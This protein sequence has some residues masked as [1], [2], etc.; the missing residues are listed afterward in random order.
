M[1]TQECRRC[2]GGFE[3]TDDECSWCG[4]PA[5]VPRW[6]LGRFLAIFGLA[7]A[8]LCI[9]VA[10]LGL[11][12][13]NQRHQPAEPATRVAAAPK[14]AQ[15]AEAKPATPA[16]VTPAPATPEDEKPTEGI[17]TLHVRE[18]WMPGDLVDPDGSARKRLVP[19]GEDP[20]IRQPA[21]G[22]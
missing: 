5:P 20:F 16:T 8:V 15:P 4:F 6:R 10:T 7:V 1:A 19:L 3:R 11:S 14:P 17:E 12:L 2:G 21:P 22:P 18:A 9:C 13:Y